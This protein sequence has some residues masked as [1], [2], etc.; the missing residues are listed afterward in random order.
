[1]TAEVGRSSDG[2][3]H[4][5]SDSM[6]R[7][8]MAQVG[9]TKATLVEGS[10]NPEKAPVSKNKGGRPSGTVSFPHN[11][12][13]DALRVPQ[14][15]WTDNAGQPF[16]PDD[17]RQSLKIDGIK[18]IRNILRSSQM[19]GL[20]IGSW[21]N[22]PTHTVRLSPVG[23]AIVDPGIDDNPTQLKRDA[24]QKPRVFSEFLRFIDG[25]VIP[26]EERCKSTLV[27]RY[28]VG[29]SVAELCYSIMMMNVR[30]LGLVV[31]DDE[32][33]D[34]LQLGNKPTETTTTT[35]SESVQEGLV[36]ESLEPSPLAG[37]EQD[38]PASND[39]PKQVFIA[40]GKNKTP[41]N[42]LVDIL[43]EFDVKYVVAIEEP[44]AGLPV[45]EK[46]AKAMHDCTSGIFIFT[47]EEKMMKEDGTEVIWPNLNVVYELGAGSA[48]YGK[49]IVILKE[50][51][52]TFPSDFSGVTHISFDKD[53]LGSKAM[54]LMKEL[55][56]MGFLQVTPT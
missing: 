26:P 40:H 43:R 28:H 17:L 50:K 21:S 20:T 14:A 4:T 9:G 39:K 24:I 31:K 36:S 1:M 38:V 3:I 42:Q 22:D 13:D 18:A 45:G 32:Q 52:V 7:R 25:R 44:N 10:G 12:L 51:G 54:D 56:T 16:A 35:E 46:V 30:S 8:D 15:I 5:P 2:A 47:A 33:R 53:N 48:I 41:L 6:H 49:K 55:V 34:T 19:Y 29:R 37:Q 11:T 27:Q 23:K